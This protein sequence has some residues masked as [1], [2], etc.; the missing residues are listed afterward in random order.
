MSFTGI[1]AF[2]LA[3]AALFG[4][5]P[6]PEASVQ[7][8]VR[9]SQ[10]KAVAGATV[11][12]QTKSTGRTLAASTDAHGVYRVAALS[13]GTYSLRVTAAGAGEATEGPFVLGAGER[14]SFDLTL[15]Y[16]FFDEPNFIVAG[17]TDTASRGG[18]GSDTVM[19]SSES[20]AQATAA[21]GHG[22]ESPAAGEAPL[23]EAIAKDPANARLHHALADSGEKQGN[24]L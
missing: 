11:Q 10:G 8:V 24:A 4:Q 17:V 1:A 7:G 21:L 14:K 12:L 13:A 6:N 19:R 15:Q 5:S 18:H 3:A 20:L 16:A 2:F 9:D 22:A 23:R